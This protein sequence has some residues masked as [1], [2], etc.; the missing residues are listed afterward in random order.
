[1]KKKVLSV[2]RNHCTVHRIFGPPP[3][4][5]EVFHSNFMTREMQEKITRI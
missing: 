1:M 5:C 3:I 2:R 4:R